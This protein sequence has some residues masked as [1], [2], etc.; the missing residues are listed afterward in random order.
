VFLVAFGVDL[1]EYS[2]EALVSFWARRQ[3]DHEPRKGSLPSVLLLRARDAIDSRLLWSK[4]RTIFRRSRSWSYRSDSSSSAS[5]CI[6]SIAER[7]ATGLRRLVPRRT[8]AWSTFVGETLS[9]PRR[10]SQL[11]PAGLRDC[12][13]GDAMEAISSAV[14]GN[15]LPV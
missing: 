6:S 15:L 5:S 11:A 4:A 9:N 10:D 14:S 2:Y 3:H 13:R 1:S 12:L 7:K 8:G